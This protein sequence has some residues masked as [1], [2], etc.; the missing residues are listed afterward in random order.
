ALAFG[1]MSSAMLLQMWRAELWKKRFHRLAP[2]PQSLWLQSRSRRLLS[3]RRILFD[4]ADRPSFLSVGIEF[5]ALITRY[6]FGRQ[7]SPAHLKSVAWRIDNARTVPSILP[8]E[9]LAFC[10]SLSKIEPCFWTSAHSSELHLGNRDPIL[11][12]SWPSETLI[13]RLWMRSRQR[14]NPSQLK[15][16]SFWNPKSLSV[17]YATPRNGSSPTLKPFCQQPVEKAGEIP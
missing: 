10:E 15:A 13:K 1:G 3:Q 4:A 12:A 11:T 5:P 8:I 16:K 14:P 9:L 6:G 7:F 2:P 17:D